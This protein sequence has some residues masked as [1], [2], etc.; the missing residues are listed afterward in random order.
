MSPPKSRGQFLVDLAN[1]NKK[2]FDEDLMPTSSIESFRM[3]FSSIAEENPEFENIDQING[4]DQHIEVFTE[5]NKENNPSINN[6]NAD[7]QIA[8]LNENG[9]NILEIIPLSTVV[10][11]D[12]PSVNED[13]LTILNKEN[14][15]DI[16]QQVDI[17]HFNE[18]NVS[19]F[20]NAGKNQPSENFTNVIDNNTMEMIPLS[21]LTTINLDNLDITNDDLNNGSN[22]QMEIIT[23]FNEENG[24]DPNDADKN[25]PIETLANEN[26]ENSKADIAESNDVNDISNIVDQNSNNVEDPDYIPET[27]ERNSDSAESSTKYNGRPGKGRKRK[28][29]DQ[30]SSIRKKKANCNQDYFSARGKHVSAKEFNDSNCGCPLKCTEKIS[31]EQRTNE[32]EKFWNS[33]SYE[34]RCAILQGSVTEVNKKRSYSNNSK[35][36][37]SRKYKLCNTGVCKKAFLIT[38]GISQSR[39][40]VALNKHR[41]QAAI[42]DKRGINSGGKNAISDEQLRQIRQFIEI[43]PKYSSHY[44]R[45][46]TSAIF[47]APN[48]NLTTIY[49]LYKEKT[50]NPVSF[51]RFRLSF[52]KDFNLRFKKPQKDTC[53]RCDLYKANKTSA[54]EKQH[55]DHLDHAYK[56]RDQ[57]KKDL[58]AAKTDPSIETLTFDLEKTH[59]LPRLPTSVVYYKRQLNLHNLGIH[60]GSDGKGYFH[61]WLEHEAG[62]G[63]QEVGSCLKKFISARMKPDRTH[64]ILWADSCGGQ[65]RSIKMV[66]M[67]L[68]ILHS[69]AKLQKITMR[70]LQPGHTYLPNDSEFG[71]VECA[72]KSNFRLYTPDDYI[73]VM[74][75][76]RR[77]NKFVVT[78]LEKDDF[79]SVAPLQNSIT[80][81]K[82]D[83]DKQK[84]SWLSTFEIELR[85]SEPTKLFMKS[86]LD[87]EARVVDISKGAKNR[88]QKPNFVLDLPILYPNGRELSSAKIQDLKELMKLVPSDAKAFYGFLRTVTPGDFVDDADGLGNSVD[89]DID[90]TYIED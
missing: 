51:S 27:N 56:L 25:Q 41:E 2:T 77:K 23:N 8:T 19:V 55:Q 76:C 62:R 21:P 20:S 18:E 42:N 80:N 75:N 10:T 65:N 52:Y 73:A 34:A 72:L 67:L 85:R 36:T 90:E 88:K 29:I 47:L 13:E 15:Y 78:R 1:S 61:I 83:V 30:N 5:S 54:T 82:S 89:F 70:F 58:T 4:K 79:Q 31:I 68:H 63:T 87:E 46:S 48:L 38:L 57:M 86:N 32:F 49:D 60:S 12:L 50:P 74:E 59:C 35:R 39:I 6:Y 3:L 43:L 66:L 7:Q 84:I 22:L 69:H 26:D 45:D 11:I 17:I 81:R 16:N 28:Y 33:G 40:D 9:E 53:L 71:D 64:L 14:S 37:F 24:S 44:C